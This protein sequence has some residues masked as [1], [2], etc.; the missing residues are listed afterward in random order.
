MASVRTA[1]GGQ[2]IGLRRTPVILVRASDSGGEG[3]GG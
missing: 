1:F 3:T 2:A